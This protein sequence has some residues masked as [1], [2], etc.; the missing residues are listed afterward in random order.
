MDKLLI[1][2]LKWEC[3]ACGNLSII[4]I[5]VYDFSGPIFVRPRKKCVC[6]TKGRRYHLIDIEKKEYTEENTKCK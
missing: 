5:P 1:L 2:E 6:G 3:V 4:D